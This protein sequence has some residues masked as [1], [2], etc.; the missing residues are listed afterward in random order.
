MLKRQVQIRNRLSLNAL[1]GIYDQQC[2]F[3]RRDGTGHFVAEVHVTG[4]V[5]Q[6]EHIF[7]SIFGFV[8]H[9]NG[10]AFD[11]NSPLAFEVHIVERLVLHLPLC[12]GSSGLEQAVGQGAFPVVDVG[13]DAEVSN[14]F[15]RSRL[16]HKISAE[17]PVSL[18]LGVGYLFGS[19]DALYL[20]TLWTFL[21][22]K[23]LETPEAPDK[24]KTCFHD[25]IHFD[26]GFECCHKYAVA[27]LDYSTHDGS[28]PYV[29]PSETTV[30]GILERYG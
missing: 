29:Q 16:G 4:S 19:S 25:A 21:L 8:S 11:G 7:L 13:N 30:D 28:A 27:Q 9:L 6:I 22:W 23:T 1:R 24:K 20:Q 14:V 5:N 12:N 18:R 26:F 3:A 10:V 2:S 17:C 15:H